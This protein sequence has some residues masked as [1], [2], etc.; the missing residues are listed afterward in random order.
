[1]KNLIIILTSVLLLSSA[2]LIKGQVKTGYTAARI[3]ESIIKQTNSEPVPNTVDVFKAGDPDTEVTG[4]VTTMFAT[5]D[6]LKK[7]V[8]IG[9]N[10]II[11]HE[12]VFYN[13]LDNTTQ[14]QDDP[15]FL[16][17][18]R[19]IDEHK[20]VIWRF[21]DYIHRLKPDGI[22]YGMALKLGWLKYTDGTVPDRFT[23]PETTLGDLLQ[24]LKKIF[25]GNAFHV[26]GKPEM[27]IKNIAFSAGAPGSTAHFRLLREEGVDVVIAGEVPQWETYE[28]VRDAVIEGKDKAIIF[29][30]H[31]TSEEPGM[32]YC[33]E[34]LKGFIKGI[35]VHFIA[36]TPS[37]WTY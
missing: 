31:V 34:W 36:S 29:L 20:L 7:A 15:V 13:H 26:I 19:Y 8:A 37:Y 17:K 6:V 30:G 2:G 35:P 1:M 21:H 23:V 16:E 25:P 10:L 3:T 12:P 33:A 28:Y 14:F 18:K 24:Y 32:E 11:A 4:I 9:C 22:D 5:M 27:R